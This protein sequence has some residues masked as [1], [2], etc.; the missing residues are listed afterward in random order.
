MAHQQFK[1]NQDQ[2][3]VE[4][5]RGA[6]IYRQEYGYKLLTI[7]IDLRAP[8]E[9]SRVVSHFGEIDLVENANQ[10]P[11]CLPLTALDVS[12]FAVTDGAEIEVT[13][14]NRGTM[15]TARYSVLPTGIEE[16]SSFLWL[17]MVASSEA[18]RLPV[19]KHS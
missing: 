15:S 8:D 3:S 18:R 16:C 13:I 10:I 14:K 19:Q 7:M 6:L 2:K 5:Y 17:D 9:Q 11:A 4:G 1:V 12:H